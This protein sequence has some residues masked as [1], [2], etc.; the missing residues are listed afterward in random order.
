[1]NVRKSLLVLSVGILITALIFVAISYQTVQAQC[2]VTGASCLPPSP[3]PSPV[4]GGGGGGGNGGG[5]R[6]KPPLILPTRTPTP[7]AIQTFT[8]E[9]LTAQPSLTPTATPCVLCPV[10]NVPPTVVAGPVF[11]L[12]GVINM[13]IIIALIA[14]LAG[15][16]FFMFRGSKPSGPN[17]PSNPNRPPNPNDSANQF[18]K[19]ED[20]S[21]Q[22]SKMEDGSNQFSKM[23]DDLNPQPLPPKGTTDG[24]DQ[25]IKLDGKSQDIG[26]SGGEQL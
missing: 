14:L 3:P 10:P 7:N 4:G 16:L 17:E 19:M 24:A 1:M 6:S 15:A 5:K 21:N 11:L 26:G 25:F 18:Y 23:E 9:T 22:F 13:L 12:P 2:G 20:G 8:A